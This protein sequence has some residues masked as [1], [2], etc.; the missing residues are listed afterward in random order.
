MKLQWIVDMPHGKRLGD[1]DLAILGLLLFQTV[2]KNE[3][4]SIHTIDRLDG[5][6]PFQVQARLVSVFVDDRLLGGPPEGGHQ[7]NLV[8]IYLV[9]EQH[10]E[11]KRQQNHAQS[12]FQD[13][14]HRFRV[15]VFFLPLSLP[16]DGLSLIETDFIRYRVQ[17]CP[18]FS[19][20]HTNNG[21]CRFR[22]AKRLSCFS[23]APFSRVEK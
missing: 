18:L 23:P 17:A 21:P 2:F 12:N 6:R 3:I 19:N 4:A 14:I 7:H 9:G 1:H 10:A 16:S 5:P 20:T 11:K 13:P 22:R 15:P 8:E